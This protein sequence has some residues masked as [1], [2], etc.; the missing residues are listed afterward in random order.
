MNQVGGQELSLSAIGRR[1]IWETSGMKIS[2]IYFKE[3]VFFFVY[4]SMEFNA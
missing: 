1:N 3:N 4:R 2:L